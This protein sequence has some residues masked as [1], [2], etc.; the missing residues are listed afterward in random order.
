M[1][2]AQLV[3]APRNQRDIFFG[4]AQRIQPDGI[5]KYSVTAQTRDTND[6]DTDDNDDRTLHLNA[7]MDV[8][9]SYCSPCI[10]GRLSSTAGSPP[11]TSSWR[12]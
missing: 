10:R 8:L 9:A 6:V 4:F 12:C 7:L 5:R 2:G 1:F 11:Q 3:F